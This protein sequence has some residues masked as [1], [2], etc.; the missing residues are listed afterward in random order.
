M[1]ADPAAARLVAEL[2][3]EGDDVRVLHGTAVFL[4][5]G[6]MG[7]LAVGN[8]RP[9]AVA[10]AEA[11]A[12]VPRTRMQMLGLHLRSLQVVLDWQ[13]GRW[14]EAERGLEAFHDRH[15]D[16]PLNSGGL[17]ATVRGL[18]A[19][20]RGRTTQ[21]ATAFEQVLT[22]ECLHLD[23][24]G[25]AA[26]TA[27]LHLT[28]GDPQS[29][30]RTLTDPLDFLDLL[31]RKEAWAH[32]W[33]LLPTAVETLLTLDRT[34]EARELTERHAT[35]TDGRDAPGA[36]AEHHLCRGL[37]LRAGGPDAAMAAFDLAAAQ[38]T[39]IGRPYHAALAA[40]HAVRTRTDPAETETRLAGPLATFE[41]LGA[42]SDAARCHHLLRELGR[43]TPN[44]RG[45]AGYGDRLSP[46][47]QQI[48]DLL[49]TGATNK[50]IAAALFLSTRTVENHVARVLAKLS[51]TRA[52]LAR[53][54]A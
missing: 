16:S 42:T 25:A 30:W 28:R 27:R 3:R 33:D 49:V 54:Q 44:L 43:K 35:A 34:A 32:A 9:A 52:D 22:R 36:V 40:E 46:R 39:D 18:L 15:P 2:P 13:A 51:T 47:E 45:R 21:A 37:L 1:A 24:L 5:A 17:L 31:D 48:R 19:A 38:W 53:R 50:D 26:G 23:S 11:Q 12:M 20:A 7:A 4:S 14:D 6:V 41:R 10:L 29:A 8:D